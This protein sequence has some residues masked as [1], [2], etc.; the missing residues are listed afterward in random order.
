MHV[1]FPF[2]AIAKN[3]SWPPRNPLTHPIVRSQAQYSS[4]DWEAILHDILEERR[5]IDT[6]ADPDCPRV[7]LCSTIINTIPLQMMLW[8]NYGYREDQEPV[9]KV[10]NCLEKFASKRFL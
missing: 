7:I 5:I 2:Q 8:R 4:T 10:L 6:C 9:Y 1:L 3:K